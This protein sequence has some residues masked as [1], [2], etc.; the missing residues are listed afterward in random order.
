MFW[1]QPHRTFFAW[2]LLPFAWLFQVILILRSFLYK[3]RIFK[4][5]HFPV[6]IV[7]VGNLTVGGTGKTPLVI[8]LATQLSAQGVTVGIV[9]RGYGGKQVKPV[10]VSVNSDPRQVGDEPVL[11][12]R[13]C[14]C[15][16]VVARR[17]AQAV[18]FLLDQENV[19]CV[20]SDDGLQHQALARSVEIVV[21]DGGRQFGNRM[22]LPAG[23]LREPIGRLKSVDFI[24][25]N[26]GVNTNNVLMTLI[27]SELK[28]VMDDAPVPLTSIA[29]K[30]ILAM[31]GIGNPQRFFETLKSLSVQF[32]QKIF[33]DHY[34][35]QKQ[36][37]DFERADVIIM[38]EKDAVKCRSFADQRH[39]YLPVEAQLPAGF[40]GQI[41][42]AIR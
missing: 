3:T 32:R 9:S 25:E 7:V 24:V 30:S 11:M 36:D 15:P 29:D 31:A 35:F 18:Q 8:W 5:H 17:R 21:V 14:G 16:V 42:S 1:Y 33:A 37:I 22:C 39:L 12:A 19:Q 10:L 23:P 34:A 40:L 13:H 26:G 6:P 41:L 20:I 38:T 28:R 2:L 27:P 4:I